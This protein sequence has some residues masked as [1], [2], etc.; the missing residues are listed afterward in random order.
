MMGVHSE[1]IDAICSWL[2]EQGVTVHFRDDIDGNEDSL[3]LYRS[4]TRE[5]FIR[6]GESARSTLL[7]LAHE[8]GH[9]VGTTLLGRRVRYHFQA[10]RQAYAYGWKVL[11]LFAPHVEKSD[12]IEDCRDAS[13]YF[14]RSG[15]ANSAAG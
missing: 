12:W 10:E 1:A 5:I 8:A 3:G 2:R 4:E 6:S 15:R 11:Q 14:R 13:T 9:W 7:T